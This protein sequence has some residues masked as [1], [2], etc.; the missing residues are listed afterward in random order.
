M[1]YEQGGEGERC[2]GFSAYPE[3]TRSLGGAPRVRGGDGTYLLLERFSTDDRRGPEPVDQR[4]VCK[5]DFWEWLGSLQ[6][7]VQG[8]IFGCSIEGQQLCGVGVCV[9][10]RSV[11][12]HLNRRRRTDPSRSVDQRKA[13][14]RCVSSVTNDSPS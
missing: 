13:I 10:E 6:A 2:F 4:R 14:H 5:K 12:V 11:S 1:Y 9:D 3:L 7:T 8:E